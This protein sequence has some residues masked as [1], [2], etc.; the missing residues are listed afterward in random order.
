MTNPMMDVL[1]ELPADPLVGLQPKLLQPSE[2]ALAVPLL[3]ALPSPADGP[4][5][6]TYITDWS[7]NHETRDL[8]RG[9]MTL[10]NTNDVIVAL[11]FFALRA[12]SAVERLLHVPRLRASDATGRHATLGATLR[13]IATLGERM[14]CREALLEAER[15]GNAWYEIASALM[16]VGPAH[17]FEPRGQHW[18]RLLA[19]AAD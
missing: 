6:H 14:G 13:T 17:G 3:G 16:H 7:C 8:H 1:A 4:D 9:I 2:S 18:W 5:I 19:P 11:F 10:R 12:E 15:A